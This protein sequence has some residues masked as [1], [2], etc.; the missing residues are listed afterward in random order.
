MRVS[1]DVDP[2]SIGPFYVYKRAQYTWRIS[3]DA[4]ETKK[5]GGRGGSGH[6]Q[7]WS[8]EKRKK[9]DRNV[10]RDVIVTKEEE[11]TP[12]RQTSSSSPFIRPETRNA[13]DSCRIF[14]SF[15]IKGSFAP[16]SSSSK[17]V[18]KHYNDDWNTQPESWKKKILF[19]T[20]PPAWPPER[21][22]FRLGGIFA[23][24]SH[25]SVVTSCLLFLIGRF[26]F[27]KTQFVP[28]PFRLPTAFS[29][30]FF[31]FLLL[32]LQP[33]HQHSLLFWGEASL[34]AVWRQCSAARPARV[35]LAS[36]NHLTHQ[37]SSI[38]RPVIKFNF[39][40]ILFC[41]FVFFLRSNQ[42]DNSR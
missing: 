10:K 1:F 23:C 27:D 29:L 32:P 39:T 33:T 17:R 37:L 11:T 7:K 8:R 34:F 35:L 31:F 18:L 42:K 5:G 41:G 28:P 24:A 9:E 26:L 3:N 36:F 14:K 19:L 16:S 4:T 20:F 21:N 25:R 15:L 13:P 40:Q 2:K 12:W 22:A 6:T 38:S 30:S